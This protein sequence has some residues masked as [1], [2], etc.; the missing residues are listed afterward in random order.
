MEDF[1]L[2]HYPKFQDSRDTGSRS[3]GTYMWKLM[4][5]RSEISRTFGISVG[6]E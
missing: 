1:K 4:P 5:Y 2:T 6:G 3:C